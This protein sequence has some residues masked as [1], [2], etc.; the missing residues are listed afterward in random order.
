M[1]V[2]EK[3]KTFRTWPLSAQMITFI[4]PIFTLLVI[5]SVILFGPDYSFIN[6]HMSTLGAQSANPQ[7]FVYFD[8]ACIITGVLLVPYFFGL[9]RWRTE[10]KILN[11]SLYVVIGI[12]F[13]ACFG[14]VMQAIYRGDF[15][16][17]HFYYSAIHWVA[18]AFLLLI[19]PIAL[20][21]AKKFYRP[22]IIVGLIA[23]VFNIYYIAT[24]GRDGWIEWI[25][26]I[27]TLLFG[28]L[29]GI[30]MVKEKL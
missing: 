5:I 3:L 18:D 19:A 29:I 8:I 16:L 10:D 23:T 27:S 26:A 15:G 30:N 4:I 7:G 22:I 11:F 28:V 17:E 14:I 12:G 25:T 20:L 13:I 24:W 9:R 6:D 2:K 1:N 21:R